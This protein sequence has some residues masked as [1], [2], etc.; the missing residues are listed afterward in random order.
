[1]CIC[2]MFY[3]CSFG[4]EFVANKFACCILSVLKVLRAGLPIFFFLLNTDFGSYSILKCTDLFD[5]HMRM[6]IGPYTCIWVDLKKKKKASGP[7]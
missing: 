6:C 2:K 4:Y 3:M 5:E 1:M 7:I